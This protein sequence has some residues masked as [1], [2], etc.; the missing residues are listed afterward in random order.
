[1]R[2]IGPA[3]GT[4]LFVSARAGELKDPLVRTRGAGLV[5]R[6]E[7]PDRARGHDT[8]A[9]SRGMPAGSSRTWRGWPW[10]YPAAADVPS[11][12]RRA[13]WQRVRPARRGPAWREEDTRVRPRLAPPSRAI[14]SPSEAPRVGLVAAPGI[15]GSVTRIL[16]SP[17]G[18]LACGVTLV[19][20][21]GQRPTCTAAALH[22]PHS[23]HRLRSCAG[24]EGH[25]APA[26]PAL[27]DDA[28][29]PIRP[30]LPEGGEVCCVPEVGAVAI[31]WF[32]CPA[33]RESGGPRRPSERPHRWSAFEMGPP[34]PR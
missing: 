8:S 2:H 27:H 32:R 3:S 24:G 30:W 6:G 16:A 13:R 21:S 11:S 22:Q 26:P 14:S 10:P 20:C 33:C 31:P 4:Y 9:R 12:F 17:P 34:E 15:P 18:S 7:V 23:P 25:G 1:M 5:G 28:P 29:R 19:G